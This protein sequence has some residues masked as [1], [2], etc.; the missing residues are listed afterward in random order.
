MIKNKGGRPTKLTKK[1]LD[2]TRILLDAQ[3]NRG[4][5]MTVIALTDEELIDKINWELNGKERICYKTLCKWKNDQKDNKLTGIGKEFFN[6]YK[7]AVAQQKEA[8]LTNMSK[9]DPQWTRFA[10]IIE[11]K[12]KEWNIQRRSLIGEDKDNKFTSLADALKDM[13]D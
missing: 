1:F 2:V 13:K 4:M 11:R 3:D 10:W 8:L 7:K 9:T 6:L 12:F 5:N